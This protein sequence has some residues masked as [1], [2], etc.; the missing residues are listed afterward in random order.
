M[1]SSS[2]LHNVLEN[3][4]AETV[5]NLNS[6]INMLKEAHPEFYTKE[7]QTTTSMKM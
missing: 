4:V 7:M 2:V 6:V 3:F 1:T 5:K